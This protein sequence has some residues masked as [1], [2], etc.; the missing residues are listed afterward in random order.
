MGGLIPIIL[1]LYDLCKKYRSNCEENVGVAE[2][3]WFCERMIDTG[4]F[5]PS[6]EFRRN[7]IMENVP[8]VNP[9]VVHQFWTYVD[10][11]REKLDSDIFKTYWDHILTFEI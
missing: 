9:Y 7:H 11:F 8:A 4:A 3:V 10:F 1:K 5:I 2:D 6:Y